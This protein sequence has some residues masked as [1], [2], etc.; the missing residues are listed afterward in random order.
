MK[1]IEKY[2]RSI[3]YIYDISQAKIKVIISKNFLLK[4]IFKIINNTAGFDDL[5]STLF[6]F[7]AYF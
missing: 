7:G 4:I 5:I 2:H 1:K 3:H 6:V